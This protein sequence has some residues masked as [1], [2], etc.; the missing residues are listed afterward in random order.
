M[1]R[2][3]I[4]TNHEIMEKEWNRMDV[5]RIL[6][7]YGL[8]EYEEYVGDDFEELDSDGNEG[9]VQDAK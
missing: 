5:K 2:I 7:E 3:S 8:T 1:I 6:E 4:S 9:D